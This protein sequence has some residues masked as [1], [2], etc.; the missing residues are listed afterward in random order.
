[1]TQQR[2]VEILEI[3]RDHVKEDAVDGVTMVNFSGICAVIKHLRRMTITTTDEYA[4]IGDY[5]LGKRPG[6]GPHYER[7]FRNSLFFWQ[8]Y[9]AEPRINWIEYRISV[10]QRKL[11]KNVNTKN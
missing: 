8:A 4:F 6:R 7:Q 3:I 5:I 11:K 10:E 1:M 9:S 2:L